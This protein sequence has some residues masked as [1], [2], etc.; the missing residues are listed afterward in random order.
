MTPPRIWRK[1]RC[2]ERRGCGG[3]VAYGW[4]FSCV[5]DVTTDELR[6]PRSAVPR[7]HVCE[8]CMPHE[9]TAWDYESD[10]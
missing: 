5:A 1:A 4:T 6:D 8:R 7:G 9:D 10:Y 3:A 2:T